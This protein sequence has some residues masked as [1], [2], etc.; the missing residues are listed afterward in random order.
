MSITVR[1]SSVGELPGHRFGDQRTDD[2]GRGE[3]VVGS[4]SDPDLAGTC[5]GVEQAGARLSA[6]EELPAPQQLGEGAPQARPAPS[7]PVAPPVPQPTKP[8]PPSPHK[9]QAHAQQAPLPP[10]A[11]QPQQ[12]Q[13][14]PPMQMPPMPFWAAPFA[15]AGMPTPDQQ[16]AMMAA[17]ARPPGP[18]EMPPGEASP[19]A[20][21]LNDGQV[22]AVWAWQQQAAAAAAAAAAAG[23]L[24]HPH[25]HLAFGVPGHSPDVGL[26]VSAPPGVASPDSTPSAHGAARDSDPASPAPTP[27]RTCAHCRTQKTP[28]WRNGPLGPKTLCNACGVRFK[29]GKLQVAA[30]GTCMAAVVPKK[31]APPAGGVLKR[32]KSS[33]RRP[34]RPPGTDPERRRSSGLKKV[35]SLA[36]LSEYDGAMLLMVLS[37]TPH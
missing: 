3:G 20:G 10:P 1:R 32:P 4:G 33:E 6:H 26:R 22:A 13:L 27:G 25:H 8:E 30:N 9:E 18:P 16:V 36:N 5:A 14:P 7:S 11:Q 35:P 28:L 15:A 37:G 17:Y 2:D 34:L 31:R 23:G 19:Q 21:P 24:K 29:L 12:P